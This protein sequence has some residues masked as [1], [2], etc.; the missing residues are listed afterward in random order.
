MEGIAT[1]SRISSVLM[2]RSEEIIQCML[3]SLTG[4]PKKFYSRV[5]MY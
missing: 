2:E 1:G 3:S 4:Y 5:S